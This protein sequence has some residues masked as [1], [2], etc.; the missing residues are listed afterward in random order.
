MDPSERLSDLPSKFWKLGSKP[1]ETSFDNLTPRDIEGLQRALT[2]VQVESG[3]IL[4]NEALTIGSAIEPIRDAIDQRIKT[5]SKIRKGKIRYA[6]AGA[7]IAAGL[8]IGAVKTLDNQPT[9]TTPSQEDQSGQ[10]FDTQNQIAQEQ[11]TETQISCRKEIP[12]SE[13]AKG[14]DEY[15][16]FVEEDTL[17]QMKVGE[18]TYT[19]PWAMTLFDTDQGTI[20]CLNGDYTSHESPGG[21]VQMLVKRTEDGYE[22]EVPI[23]YDYQIDESIPWVGGQV[24]D[25]IAVQ[26]VNEGDSYWPN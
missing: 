11:N 2:I 20:A 22:V 12:E 18:S 19:V 9:P 5:Q 7:V 25:L 15:D 3:G 10:V 6:V 13:I 1:R 24:K 17:A 14:S 16:K 8:T 4:T 26:E 21:T 23:G